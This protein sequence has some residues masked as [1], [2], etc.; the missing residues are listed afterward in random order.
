MEAL[1]C[2]PSDPLT[3]VSPPNTAEP[4]ESMTPLEPTDPDT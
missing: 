3:S 4:V 1:P 2:V